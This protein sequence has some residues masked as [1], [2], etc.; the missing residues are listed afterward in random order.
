MEAEREGAD[1]WLLKDGHGRLDV[2]EPLERNLGETARGDH[3]RHHFTFAIC[4]RLSLYVSFIALRV[5]HTS[6]GQHVTPRLICLPAWQSTLR[7]KRMTAIPRGN[8]RCA[9]S[10]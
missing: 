2:C 4:L 6:H 1:A 9:S 5:V 10:G 3:G 8:Q 7:L